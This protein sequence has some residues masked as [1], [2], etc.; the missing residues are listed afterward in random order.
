MCLHARRGAQ[1]A[2]NTT[3]FSVS[4][5]P[6][7]GRFCFVLSLKIPYAPCT[8]PQKGEPEVAVRRIW[9]RAVSVCVCGGETGEQARRQKKE[10]PPPHPLAK[11]THPTP[12]RQTG[13]SP[14]RRGR[15]TTPTCPFSGGWGAV[16]KVS[17]TSGKTK[18]QTKKRNAQSVPRPR[19]RARQPPAP[20]A[21][22]G[23][24]VRMQGAGR[25]AGRW[26]MAGNARFFFFGRARAARCEKRKKRPRDWGHTRRLSSTPLP[27][28]RAR[29]HACGC[30][31]GTCWTWRFGRAWR[32]PVCL[33][34]G[35]EWGR[36][37]LCL[38]A[39]AVEVAMWAKR[40]AHHFGWWK[41]GARGRGGAKVNEEEE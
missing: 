22:H 41:K 31:R 32:R 12:R 14:A 1:S 20:R 7:C 36:R 23:R 24:H 2:K 18:K 15:R 8:L 27:W 26:W 39:G 17:R 34:V 25:R 28:P 37:C 3:L 19:A 5:G 10:S 40:G 38:T 35:V 21:Q 6:S 16:W 11:K 33:C 13:K 4:A 9:S 29:C 30:W